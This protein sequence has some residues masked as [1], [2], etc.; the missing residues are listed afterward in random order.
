M[1]VCTVKPMPKSL[2]F[3]ACAIDTAP[4]GGPR[5]ADAR[6]ADIRQAYA[7]SRRLG[8]FAAAVVVGIV[9]AGFWNARLADGFG[10]DV[11]A[12]S[13]THLTLPTKA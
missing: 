1:A 3:D 7:T 11:V 5:T 8:Y 6:A 4:A 12:V 9:I 2:T 13:Y 10:R